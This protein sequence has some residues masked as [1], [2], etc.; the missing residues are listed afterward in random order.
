MSLFSNSLEHE[1]LRDNSARAVYELFATR[2]RVKN[3]QPLSPNSYRVGLKDGS[4]LR[5]EVGE[6]RSLFSN[7]KAF[8][9][10][11]GG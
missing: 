11:I 7:A 5:V 2:Y 1:D 4:S 10:Y 8:V 9:K 3:V 6:K